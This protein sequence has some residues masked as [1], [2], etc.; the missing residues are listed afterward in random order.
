VGHQQIFTHGGWDVYA[1]LIFF[2]GIPVGLDALLHSP[3]TYR[4]AGLKKRPWALAALVS[5]I[6]LVGPIFAVVYLVKAHRPIRAT[7]P[8]RKRVRSGG[9]FGSGGSTEPWSPNG[10]TRTSWPER[11][12]VTCP[13]GCDRGRQRHSSGYCVGGYVRIPGQAEYPCA[14]QQTCTTCNGTGRVLA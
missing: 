7:K 5:N 4:R 12:E 8:R 10:P 1:I 6:L 9:Q 11:R 14:C 2:F 13:A 3:S